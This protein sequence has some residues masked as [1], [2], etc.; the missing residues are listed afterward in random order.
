MVIDGTEYLELF[1]D[2]LGVSQATKNK[3]G[4]NVRKY[5]NWSNAWGQN[6]LHTR[7]ADLYRYK[8]FLITKKL[9]GNYLYSCLQPLK[10]FFAWLNEMGHCGENPAIR[11]NIPKRTSI[12]TKGHLTVDQVRQLLSSLPKESVIDIRNFTI[13]ALMLQSGI[14]SVEVSRLNIANFKHEDSLYF[15]EVIRKGHATSEQ[16]GISQVMYEQFSY[17]LESRTDE[18]DNNSP[19]F[20]TQQRKRNARLSPVRVSRI[21]NQVLL[22]AGMKCRTITAH[23]LRHTAAVTLLDEGVNLYDI[24]ILLGHRSI[25][26]TEIYQRSKDAQRLLENPAANIL[27]QLFMKPMEIKRNLK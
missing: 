13:V 25:K 23:S 2:D 8:E 17:Y 26:T 6:I 12:H 21:V 18:Y 1:L 24:R 5:Y 14:R 15:M 19:A 4:Q 10:A 27:T 20:V 9:S 11:L 7:P 3:Y 16:I 22:E